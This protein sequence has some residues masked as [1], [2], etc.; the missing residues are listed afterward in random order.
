MQKGRYDLMTMKNSFLAVMMLLSF[1]TGCT[2]TTTDSTGQ[3]P[4]Q[5]V[6]GQRT[7]V[8]V[9]HGL[10]RTHRSMKKIANALSE[11]GYIVANLDYPST[12]MSIEQ[13]AEQYL[14]PEIEKQQALGRSICVVTHS[15]GGILVRAYLARHPD[16]P[17]ERIVMLAPPNQGSEL[18][19]HLK[20]IKLFCFFMGPAALQLST[21]PEA[22]VQTL[23][24]PDIPTGIIAG[25]RSL[26]PLY[27][28]MIPGDDDGKVSVARARFSEPAPEVA[29]FLTVP[30]THTFLMNNSRVIARTLA[31]LEQGTFL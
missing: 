7:S 13:L 6:E 25:D 3:V 22:L 27:S 9:L 14:A 1:I 21:A 17:I 8:I 31:F 11:R 19:D 18:I 26:N 2:P 16:A 20:N 28:L 23:P 29:C 10:F 5:Q 4:C 30:C 15:M 12:D 24:V